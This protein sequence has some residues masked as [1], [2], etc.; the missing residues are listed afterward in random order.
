M[1]ELS[2]KSSSREL[3]H[4]FLATSGCQIG[5]ISLQCALQKASVTKNFCAIL[6]DHVCHEVCYY[7]SE[8]NY[9]FEC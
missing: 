5:S 2:N 7:V 8:C 4:H 3:I 9:K 1:Y 6:K